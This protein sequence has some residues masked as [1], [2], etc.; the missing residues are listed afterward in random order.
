[1]SRFLIIKTGETY[2]P[3][4]ARYGCFEDWIAAGL[5]V[6]TDRLDVRQV[7]TGEALPVTLDGIAGIIITGSSAMVSDREPWSET[8]AQWL[9]EHLVVRAERTP[10][11]GICYGHQLLAH[12]AG[13]HVDY[14]PRGR[15]IGTVN[16]QLTPCAEDDPLFAGLP[17]TWCAHVTH[18]QSAIRLPPEAVL[19]AH[20]ALEPHHAFRLGDR[21]VWGVQ[22]HPEFTDDI[23]RAYLEQFGDALRRESLCTDTLA[24]QVGV[25]AVSTAVLRRF[26]SL[27]AAGSDMLKVGLKP[28]LRI[29]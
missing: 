17:H 27:V 8:V 5:G 25:C 21:P 7:F 26:A 1:M 28:D 3:I 15:E 4:R 16:L 13:G 14:N 18:R 23:M 10:T 12:A 9:H 2:D 22:F 6:A 24:N 29:A 19:L 20:S 11:L